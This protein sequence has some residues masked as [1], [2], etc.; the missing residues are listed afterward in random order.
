M[1]FI[2][3]E[4][5]RHLAAV[6]G[7]WNT[8][9]SLSTHGGRAQWTMTIPG[10]HSEMVSKNLTINGSDCKPLNPNASL[11]HFSL[12]GSQKACAIPTSPNER[13]R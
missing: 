5:Q 6:M 13:G 7:T 3:K 9:L 8:F 12:L 11:T 10:S 1:A 2:K 4:G